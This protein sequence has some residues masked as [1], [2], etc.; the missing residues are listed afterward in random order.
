MAGGPGC[1]CCVYYIQQRSQLSILQVGQ[2]AWS[3]GKRDAARAVKRSWAAP[4]STC[5][6]GGEEER[7][8][9]ACMEG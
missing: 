1:L 7:S 8:L 2:C 6:D 5:V 3:G 4:C 9:A